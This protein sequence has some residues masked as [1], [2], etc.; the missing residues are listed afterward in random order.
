MRN[1]KARRMGESASL[2]PALAIAAAAVLAGMYSSP[3]AQAQLAPGTQIQTNLRPMVYLQYGGGPVGA[4]QT[5]VGIFDSGDPSETL[6]R[7]TAVRLGI[8]VVTPLHTANAALAR[9]WNQGTAG[10][11]TVSSAGWLGG[12][13]DLER[14]TQNPLPGG[15][16]PGVR[17]NDPAHVFTN[18]T[19]LNRTDTT[20]SNN[21]KLWYLDYNRNL[22]VGKNGYTEN[23]TSTAFVSQS[24][25]A[26][27]LVVF[28][29]PINGTPLPFAYDNSNA[30]NGRNV[31]DPPNAPD[32]N[33]AH[34]NLDQR[35]S[36]V[37]Y[38]V[39]AN[40]RVP[41]P[42][43]NTNPGF[44]HWV[45]LTP[46]EFQSTLIPANG[47]AGVVVDGTLAAGRR[48]LTLFVSNADGP[49][50]TQILP[51]SQNGTVDPEYQ[52]GNAAN[53]FLAY[54]G[55][56]LRVAT[57]LDRGNQVN[58]NGFVRTDGSV[59]VRVVDA[60]GNVRLPFTEVQLPSQAP[61]PYGTIKIPDLG[62]D[63]GAVA[64]IDTGAPTTTNGSIVGTDI[65]NRFGQFWDFR[66]VNANNH[67]RLALIGPSDAFVR[68]ALG[69][70]MVF[71]V[72]RD[73]TG[74]A[75][76][77]VEQE[78]L[79]GSVPQLQIGAATQ[80]G[81]GG[82]DNTA[83]QAQ[84][85]VFRTHL[86]GS[87]ASYID[88]NATG[89]T[90]GAAG[91]LMD[92]NTLGADYISK[93]MPVFFSVDAASVGKAG[94]DANVQKSRN[95]SA[96]D[97]YRATANSVSRAAGTN[98]LFINQEVMGLGPN[99]GPLV[100]ASAS[101]DNLRDFDL[102]TGQAMPAVS[103]S[104]LDSPI[105]VANDSGTASRARVSD[106][107]Y[108]A[109][110]DQYFSVEDKTN[111]NNGQGSK[112]YRSDLS[113]VFATGWDMGLIE[114]EDI[115]GIQADDID[116][117]ALFRPSVSPGVI[118]GALT[119]G[120]NVSTSLLQNS[121]D[122]AVFDP[123]DDRDFE[124]IDMFN[125]EAPTDLALFSLAPGSETLRV[126]SLSAADLFIT[127]FDGTFTLFATAENLGLNFTDNIDGLDTIPEPAG[128]LV[129]ASGALLMMR[130]Q[131]RS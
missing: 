6:A 28:I 63:T 74:L 36:S 4:D 46:Q 99:F 3:A 18:A 62:I 116:A 101:S 12:T 72:D 29:D 117:L 105:E 31:Y 118:G 9:N 66:N 98:Q 111:D 32:S 78:K 15:T 104:N 89:L 128:L 19:G 91:Q 10:A 26:N 119:S 97:V 123:N 96:A 102:F 114:F 87:N 113:N 37:S 106:E 76:T 25:A 86:T 70:G 122:R 39:G 38:F 73:T 43:L 54:S 65:L 53:N 20:S 22:D 64:L 50:V 14:N 112:I 24:N 85:T 93:N 5:A 59:F 131:R 47:G 81:I 44:V 60:D 125:G 49:A 61:R 95:Q 7:E 84:G 90:R 13:F 51:R 94:S 69:N 79:Y 115:S 120:A 67:G 1:G 107:R 71:N 103:M 11:T 40:P 8:N 21:L 108:A 121:I 52:P 27:N 77:G 109:N 2:H 57:G 82:G 129:L 17:A 83:N 41:T 124:G 88:E 92:G 33:P 42:E 16:E 35:G 55:Y 48:E 45:D 58:A 23:H 130:R 34:L 110:F 68:Q 100:N 30:G 75:R 127:D 126:F 56:T 80:A